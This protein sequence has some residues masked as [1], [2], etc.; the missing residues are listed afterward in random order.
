VNN[1]ICRLWTAPNTMLGLIAGWLVLAFGGRAQAVQGAL[2]FHGGLLGRLVARHCHFG[3][4][5]FGHVILGV[6]SKVLN[7]VRAHEHVHI[8]QYERWGPLF[9]PAYVAS[10]AWQLIRGRDAYLDNLFERDA[11]RRAGP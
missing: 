10:S 6:D 3:A 5:T 2:E 11:R 1:A 4:I 9:L 8:K 7:N